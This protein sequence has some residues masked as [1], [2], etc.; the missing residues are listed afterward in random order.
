MSITYIT[1]GKKGCEKA[2]HLKAIAIVVDALRAS[3]TLI[4]LIEKGVKEIY[5]VSEVED[6]WQLKKQLPE[7]LLVGERNNFKIKGFDFSNSPTEILS[8][9]SLKDK[10]IVFT[11]TSGAKGI[12]ECKQA[13]K[14]FIG[15]TLNASS[16][17]EYIRNLSLTINKPVVM[18]P[19]GIFG[20][21]LLSEEDIF[22][23]WIIA[24]KINLPIIDETGWIDE[25]LEKF[26]SKEIFYLSKHGKELIKCGLEKDVDFCSNLDVFNSIPYVTEYITEK[27]GLVK[28]LQI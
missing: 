10:I 21:E 8:L 24:K 5:V 9:N 20:K 19:C 26:S 6:A 12:L 17:G 25:R 3:A 15:T 22:S 11:S 28:K 1:P 23:A 4:T 18:I 27:I 2:N 16:L 13:Y 7:A 14:V